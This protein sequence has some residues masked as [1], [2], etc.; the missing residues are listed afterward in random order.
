MN[1]LE[2]L[3]W[4]FET[5][6]Q[7]RADVLDAI[8]DDPESVSNLPSISSENDNTAQLAAAAI[9]QQPWFQILQQISDREI[10]ATQLKN[11]AMFNDIQ[12]LAITRRYS[13]PTSFANAAPTPSNFMGRAL[14]KTA[15]PMLSNNPGRKGR[16]REWLL[17]QLKENPL[18]RRM[19][20]NI[21]MCEG[22][23]IPADETWESRAS[24]YWDIDHASDGETETI[25]SY[26]EDDEYT[27]TRAT[28]HNPSA[29]SF[30]NVT[31]YQANPSS[32]LHNMQSKLEP[33]STVSTHREATISPVTVL[34][35][36]RE[37]TV[38]PLASGQGSSQDLVLLPDEPVQDPDDSW[39]FDLSQRFE[40][41]ETKMG[42]TGKISKQNASYL[43][44]SAMKEPL[45]SPNIPTIIATLTDEEARMQ[46]K[47]SC[48]GLA[49]EAGSLQQ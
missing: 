10:E 37:A 3:R 34:P 12:L 42:V 5:L 18:Q 30:S 16:L 21:L 25:D 47:K 33:T 28:S 23:Q 40:T 31:G 29:V 36:M 43:D 4:S 41:D 45:L 44:L 7:E 9:E 35:R 17:A 13:D 24:L 19:Y 49:V 26:D 8:D 20:R 32:P 1:E 46:E 11:E 39:S 27:V 38:D 6:R 22:L 15:V 2:A 48:L 14:T